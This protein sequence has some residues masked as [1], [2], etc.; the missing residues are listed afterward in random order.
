MASSPGGSPGGSP[1]RPVGEIEEQIAELLAIKRRAERYGARD[2]ASRA[3]LASIA[4]EEQMLWEELRAARGLDPG[5]RAEPTTDSPDVL[6]QKISPYSNIQTLWTSIHYGLGVLTP[7]ALAASLALSGRAPR[8]SSALVLAAILAPT[9]QANLRARAAR[10]ARE[11]LELLLAEVEH[12][13]NMSRER[14]TELLRDVDRSY[15]GARS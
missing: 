5:R 14:L 3:T 4:H 6:K 13:G 8:A 10:K 15:T 7:L 12:L 2:F 11:R 9:L 1:A